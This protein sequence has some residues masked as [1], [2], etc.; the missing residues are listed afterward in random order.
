MTLQLRLLVLVLLG[1]GG[2]LHAQVIAPWT[3][4]NSASRASIQFLD[5]RAPEVL[6]QGEWTLL[7]PTP[8][9]DDVAC[10]MMPSEVMPP[11]L[12]AKYPG[13]GTY[14]GTT[15]TGAS[16]AM[17]IARRG[18]Y[19]HVYDAGKPSWGIEP[20][21]PQRARL[22]LVAELEGDTPAI[23]LSCGYVPSTS[24]EASSQVKLNQNATASAR[25]VNVVKRRYILALATTGEFGRRY[26]PEK[27]DIAATL[28]QAV[29]IL[30]NITLREVAAE[31]QLHPQ[32]DTLIFADAA[33]DPYVNPTVGGAL[34]SENPPAINNRI[35]ID[36][37][38]VGHVF[39]NACS[40]V[41]GVVS[42]RACSASGK[43]RGVTCHYA[44][45]TRIVEEVMAH[46]VAHQFA[47]SHSWNNCP[48]N[49]GQRAGQGAY[50]PGSG[51]TIMSYQGA[52]GSDNNV[53]RIP[54]P[55]YYHVGSLQQF[56]DFTTTGSGS[57][58]ADFI[59]TDNNY[60]V[61]DWPYSDGFAIPKETPFVL[62]ASATDADGD[63]LLYNWEQYDLGPS[64]NLCD[65]RDNTP[66]FR[67]LPPQPTGNRRY[68]PA[69]NT[70]RSG[71]EDCEEQLPEFARELNFRMT[72]RDRSASGGGTVWEQVQFDVTDEGP[73]EV[74]SQS[75]L[76]TT[77]VAG[78]FVDVT[79]DV[80]GTNVAPVNCERVNILLS[81][82]DG[83]TFPYMLAEDT[84]NDG[85]E[86]VTLPQVD[87]SN[88][89][90]KVEAAENIFYSLSASRFTI[91]EPTEPGFTFVPSA[92]TT[93]LCLPE[94]VEIDL[95]TSPLLGYDSTLSVSIVNNL[96]S[97]V[98]ATLSD[99]EVTPG[100]N[101]VLSLDF[102][103]FNET[104][105][106]Y[107]VL[108]AVGP[109]VDTARRELLFDV[110]SNDFSD[111]SL[112]GPE[113][114]EINVSEVPTF[115]FEPTRRAN[116]FKLEVSTDPRFGLGTIVV[117]NPDPN[118]E[119]LPSQLD[120][121][122]VYF[123]RVV[124]SNR[125]GEGL[126]VPIY[127]FNTLAA[128]CQQFR[129][130]EVIIIPPRIRTVREAIIPV[131]ASGAVN[132][133]NLPLVDVVY[134][135]V[136]DIRVILEAPTGQSVVLLENR[137]G[138]TN[139]LITG[140]DDESP[141]IFDCN[142]LPN[143]GVR[144]QPVNPLSAFDGVNIQGDWKL[145]VEV[146]NPSNDGGEFRAFEVEFCANIVSQAPTLELNT[147]EVPTAQFQYLDRQ[148][149]SA[150]DADSGDSD[151]QFYLVTEPQEGHL[152]LYD[153][154][155][156]VGQTWTMAMAQLGALTYV[157][158][159]SEPGTDE[160]DIV[161]SDNAGNIIATPTVDVVIGDD[162]MISTEDASQRLV[163]MHLQPNPATGRTTLQ[164]DQPSQGGTARLLDLQGREV[165]RTLVAAGQREIDFDIATLPAGVYVMSYRGAEGAQSLR[166]VKQ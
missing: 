8:D 12:A 104:D 30:N 103:N 39:T 71:N 114:G 56:T 128:S 61:I 108:E 94:D 17:T 86:G 146:V 158:D 165:G 131:S 79:W 10:Q 163:A 136:N 151:L 109:D 29:N 112:L 132:D 157:H 122:T 166:L 70:V 24:E 100:E 60:P 31:F 154:P 50:E 107:V 89:R 69:L 49:D 138:G 123:W 74:T 144:R 2:S 161:L 72:V 23:P 16:V 90:I 143:D 93:F 32:N 22:G 52:C 75:S 51:S 1:F 145:Q 28:A 36:S 67:S 162:F 76:A 58:C 6:P 148:Y 35:S 44:G 147:V 57:V 27:A 85:S 18:I 53:D 140:F 129:R 134:S 66:L 34:L 55:E 42:G 164:F 101:L 118:G 73:F 21:G 115:R 11:Q 33:N 125:C 159:G 82:D 141:I 5:V 40:D 98:Q 63:D 137:C 13:V 150:E 133:L 26:G 4:S 84:N 160:F 65:Q 124:P 92:T 110:V 95:F 9:G 47:V 81:M 87:G 149:I 120:P 54:A 106:V 97:G 41:G 152:E 113:N 156:I 153:Q 96:P 3:S 111:L 80:A 38:D 88:A 99:D 91:V 117:E 25:Q 20:I 46:E 142:P 14:R 135:D 45:L 127:A 83:R 121:N 116:E 37:Y 126:D 59:T 77:Y 7:L 15:E 68:F 64:V 43:A 139:R 130:E 119:N 48:G 105:S 19:V 78:S 155:I 62:S 102:S